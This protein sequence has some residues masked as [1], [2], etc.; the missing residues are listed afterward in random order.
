MAISKGK[1]GKYY[2]DKML[3]NQNSQASCNNDSIRLNRVNTAETGLNTP[4]KTPLK[5]SH[6]PNL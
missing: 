1:D 5:R 6:F 3:E 2:R 4:A